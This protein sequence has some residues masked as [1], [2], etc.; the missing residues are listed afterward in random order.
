MRLISPVRAGAVIAVCAAFAACT[1]NPGGSEFND[2]Y[3]VQNRKVHRFNLALDRALVRPSSEVYGT[4]LPQPVRTGVGNFASNLDL[5]GEVVNSILQ[6]RAEP[7]VQNT[8]RFL[9]N[10]TLGVAGLFDP[11]TS[12]GVPEHDTDF[13]ETLAVWGVREGA[14]LVVPALGPST[15]RAFTGKVVDV[16]LNPVGFALNSPESEYATIAKLGS[17]IG[18]RYRFSDTLDSILYESADSYSQ[19]RL[20]YLQNQ[21]FDLGTETEADVYDPYEDPY[22]E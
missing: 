12:I 17:K 1:P 15:E 9:I 3:E 16:L 10:S 22:G 7:A 21:R 14:Y 4:I 2:P 19:T 6:G 8:F 20:L 5:P 13:G 18:D 11:A